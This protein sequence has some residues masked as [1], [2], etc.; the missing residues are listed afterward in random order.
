[1]SE[2]LASSVGESRPPAAQATIASATI[3]LNVP[4]TAT[5]VSASDLC[6]DLVTTV[7]GIGGAGVGAGAGARQHS[8]RRPPSGRQPTGNAGAGGDVGRLAHRLAGLSVTNSTR[9][10]GPPSFTS[11]VRCATTCQ[12]QPHTSAMASWQARLAPTS[13]PKHMPR[14]ASKRCARRPAVWAAR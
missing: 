3:K 12:T 11:C 8:P 10:Q 6:G 5:L 1:M 4:V 7:R 14:A 2:R 9:G 13:G